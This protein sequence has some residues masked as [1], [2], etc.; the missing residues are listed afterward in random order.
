MELK[1]LYGPGGLVLLKS[2]LELKP[3]PGTK[4]KLVTGELI[5]AIVDCFESRYPFVHAVD[6]APVH[7][8]R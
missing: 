5:E 4:L 8:T 1:L 2:Y 3:C 6:P 7:L